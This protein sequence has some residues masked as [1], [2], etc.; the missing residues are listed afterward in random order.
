MLELLMMQHFLLKMYSKKPNAITKLIH[1]MEQIY[2][3]WISVNHR[4]E[5]FRNCIKNNSFLVGLS[6]LVHRAQPAAPAR[7]HCHQAGTQRDEK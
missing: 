1:S 3:K 7:S 2:M 5:N 4:L 6:S